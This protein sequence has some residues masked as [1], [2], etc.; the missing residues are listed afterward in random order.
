MDHIGYFLLIETISF[1]CQ[2]GTILGSPDEVV[3]L[4]DTEITQDLF[5]DFLSAVGQED[6]RYILIH[7]M[8][9]FSV[10]LQVNEAL[11]TKL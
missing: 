2:G 11:F 3:D 8:S 7:F 4:G 5:I 9:Y 1:F 10:N 6:F